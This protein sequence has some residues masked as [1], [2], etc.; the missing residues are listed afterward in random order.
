[1]LLLVVVVLPIKVIPA[2][3]EQRKIRIKKLRIAKTIS[4]KCGWQKKEKKH[5]NKTKKEILNLS[6]KWLSQ[7]WALHV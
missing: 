7:G 2:S 1:M 6:F 5:T 3:Q 4:K